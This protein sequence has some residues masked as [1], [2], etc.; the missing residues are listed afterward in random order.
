MTIT[1][2]FTSLS[3]DWSTSIG[4]GL[5][6]N[7]LWSWMIPVVLGWVYVGTQ[8]S[9]GSVKVALTEA[10]VPAL[11]SRRNVNGDCFGIRDRTYLDE[12]DTSQQFSSALNDSQEE[13]GPS[14]HSTLRPPERLADE[15]VNET[16]STLIQELTSSKIAG[17]RI[18]GTT[19]QESP[20][21]TP[22]VFFTGQSGDIKMRKLSKDSHLSTTTT[23]RPIEQPKALLL[24]GDDYFRSLPKT[25][26]GLPIAG[27]EL[28]P[29]PM[30]N[31]ARL[32]THANAVKH[33]TDAFRQLTVR[34]LRNEPVA[35]GQKWDSDPDNWRDNLQGS[36]EE[37]SRYINPEGKDVVD[38]SIHASASAASNFNCVIAA[39][40]AVFLQWGTAGAA[41]VIAYG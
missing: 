19:Q 20:A 37:Y 38:F 13:E 32:W 5:S 2:F 6:M 28:E 10:I 35:R 40:V 41:I 8:I 17:Y 33:I 29:G 31:Y 3:T 14:Q 39:F 18:C 4:L 23:L 7:C 36:P 27:D 25:C 9:A 15:D 30:F 16:T 24:G 26:M 12:F 21:G 11:G 1:S 22:D 34:Q